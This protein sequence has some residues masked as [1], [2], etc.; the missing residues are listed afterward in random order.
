M[1]LILLGTLCGGS[2]RAFHRAQNI[3]G[4]RVAIDALRSEQTS[5][6]QRTLRIDNL[7]VNHVHG[8]L[9]LHIVICLVGERSGTLHGLQFLKVCGL[10]IV[11]L[12]FLDLSDVLHDGGRLISLLDQIL[13]PLDLFYETLTGLDRFLVALVDLGHQ[14]LQL[15][16]LCY[17]L[18][19]NTHFFN[20]HKCCY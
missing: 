15:F 11:G 3:I 17:K 16:L 14:S 6:I 4:E 13:K 2:D 20:L 18:F 8:G 19:L 5:D 12:L 10:G 7:I 1:D 9:C